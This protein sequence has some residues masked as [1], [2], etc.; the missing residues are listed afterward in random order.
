MLKS[1]ITQT[2]EILSIPHQC[3]E[4]TNQTGIIPQYQGHHH[5]RRDVDQPEDTSKQ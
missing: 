4:W 1:P 3:Q 2:K 5:D